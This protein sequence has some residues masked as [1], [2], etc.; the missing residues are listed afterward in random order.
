MRPSRDTRGSAAIP[1]PRGNGCALVAVTA[2]VVAVVAIETRLATLAF[3]LAGLP[4]LAAILMLLGSLA[5]SAVDIP[6]GRSVTRPA[7]TEV[8]PVRQ[9]GIIFFLPRPVPHPTVIAVNVG[10]ALIPVGVSVYLLARGHLWIAGLG[11]RP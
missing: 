4:P 5:G 11:R 9:W 10:G 7:V 3:G 8:Q 1:S 6:V 2:A